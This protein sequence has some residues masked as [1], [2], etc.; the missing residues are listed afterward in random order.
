MV[1]TP[2]V[3]TIWA[4]RMLAFNTDHV[5]IYGPN[6]C[7]RRDLITFV[8]VDS[9]PIAVCIQSIIASVKRPYCQYLCH[10]IKLHPI[11]YFYNYV[12]PER[13]CTCPMQSSFLTTYVFIF[14]QDTRDNFGMNV[15]QVIEK[16]KMH[17]NFF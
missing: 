9:I 15:Q 16:V 8:I 17:T 2:S 12:M 11:I 10:Q 6:S 5:M 13:F 1:L 14:L 4:I 3:V 7:N